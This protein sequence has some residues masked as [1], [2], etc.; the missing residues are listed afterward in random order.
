MTAPLHILFLEDSRTDAELAEATLAAAGIACEIERVETREAFSA[1]LDRGGFDLICSDNRLPSFDGLSALALAQV[2]C[3]HVPF[4]FVSGT[5]GE[6]TAIE[7]LKNGATDYVLK[8]RLSRLVPAVQRALKELE[9]RTR[10]QRAEETL[11]KSEER[12][13]ALAENSYD[14]VAIMDAEGTISYVSPSVVRT[15]GYRVADVIGKCLYDFVHPDDVSEAREGLQVLI[16]NA[17]IPPGSRAIRVRRADGAWRVLE[18]MGNNLLDNP[19][20]AG[21]VLNLRDITERQEAEEQ[22]HRQLER[23]TALRTIDRAISASL[24][25][26]VTLSVLLGQV[27]AQLRVDAASIL[28]LNPHTQMLEYAAGR[29]F[30]SRAIQQSKLRL[31]QGYAGQAALERR[32]INVP[33]LAA[34]GYAR[35]S[36]LAG[37]DFC[38]YCAAPLVTKGQLRGVLETFRRSPH[39]PEQDWAEFL[40]AFAQQAAIAINNAELFQGLQKSNTEL[41]LAYETTIEAWSRV[42]DLRDKET[43][44][45]SRRVTEMT[46]SLGRA[47]NLSEQE[48]VHARRGALLHDIGKMGVPD[49]ILLKPGALTEEE[50]GIM[51]RHPQLAYDML[52]PIEYLRPALEIP[53]CHH[54]KWDGTG[55]PRGLGG[56]QIPVAAR[57]FAVADVWDA[58]RSDRPYRAAWSEIKA[59]AY[60][61]EQAGTHF[62]PKVVEAFLHLALDGP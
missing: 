28:L 30:R 34:G 20:V 39:E 23:V 2:K 12:F 19:A 62:D 53:Y 57:I 44:G 55:Y 48:L 42:L 4:I 21:I 46:M 56:E 51:K 36:L 43:E 52:A 3:P 29:G 27:I 7:S 31:G 59:R 22:V 38:A 35:K 13:H 60:V 11:R 14:I 61:R 50:W 40:E 15:L 41:A 25:L 5:L 33:N 18:G 47:L 8:H 9:E 45:H 1:A 16:A 17:T 54:E 24:D 58:L 32:V 10:R 26:G 49:N 37:E 6:E